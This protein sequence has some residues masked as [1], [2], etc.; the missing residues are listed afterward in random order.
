MPQSSAV[1]WV[2]TINFR[3]AN[4]LS[5]HRVPNHGW[6]ADQQATLDNPWEDFHE[7][8][9]PSILGQGGVDGSAKRTAS[10]GHEQEELHNRFATDVCRWMKK[11]TQ[12]S[13]IE[14]VNVFAPSRVLGLIR[15]QLADLSTQAIFHDCDIANLKPS[16]IATHPTVV[17]SLEPRSETAKSGS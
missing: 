15:E 8:D 3:Q 11:V 17:R 1:Q 7:H 14:S 5:C 16:E 12:E 2:I 6:H 10:V 13:K 4:L 9:R